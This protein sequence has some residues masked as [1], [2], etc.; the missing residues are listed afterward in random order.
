MEKTS[1]KIIELRKSGMSINQIS[2]ELGLAKSTVSTSIKRNAP[3]LCG[4]IFH[5][6]KVSYCK[7]CGKET[8]NRKRIT[9]SKEC[10]IKFLKEKN[11]YR[12][13]GLKSVIAQKETKRSKNEILFAR[14]CK[15][16]FNTILENEPMFNGWDADVIIPDFKIAILWNGP[17]HYKKIKEKHY[18]EQVQNRDQIKIK[19]IETLGY[20]AYIIKDDGKYNKKFVYSKFEKFKKFIS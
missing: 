15:E 6:V 11:H 1:F 4:A 5:I 9:C 17:W 3:E 12:I 14:L 18:L 8:P 10:C 20:K 13:N 16:E 19:E 7:N 2:K